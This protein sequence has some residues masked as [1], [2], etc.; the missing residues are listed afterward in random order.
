LLQA[1]I[2][3]II[4][5]IGGLSPDPKITDAPDFKSG[6]YSEEYQYYLKEKEAGGLKF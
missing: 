5:T 6:I 2:S 1:G 3:E 4:N